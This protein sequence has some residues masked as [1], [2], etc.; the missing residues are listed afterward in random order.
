MLL[1]V[2]MH[3]AQSY[4][5]KVKWYLFQKNKTEAL[6]V[7]FKNNSVNRPGQISP[8]ESVKLTTCKCEQS[9]QLKNHTTIYKSKRSACDA[10]NPACP[11][12]SAM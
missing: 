4:F 11:P 6:F 7:A 10:F 3:N 5:L 2:C 1:S 9:E 8:Q 12:Y